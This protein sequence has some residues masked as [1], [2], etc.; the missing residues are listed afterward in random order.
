MFASA[1]PER[2]GV[3]PTSALPELFS[4]V[5]F[6]SIPEQEAAQLLA[7]FDPEGSGTRSWVLP[8]LPSLF[9]F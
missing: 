3:I 4:N 8:M 2:T 9:F 5:G 6:G 7:V 1:D